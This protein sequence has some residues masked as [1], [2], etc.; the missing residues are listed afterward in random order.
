LEWVDPVSLGDN[1]ANWR[2]HPERQMNALKDLLG[3]SEVGWAGVLLFNEKTGHLIDGHARKKAAIARGEAAVPV[4][5][6]NWSPAAERKILLT[7]DPLAG[8][9]EFDADKLQSLLDEVPLGTDA[10]D[11]LGDELAKMLEEGNQQEA[12]GNERDGEAGG[13]G[14]GSGSGEGNGAG[15]Q[16]KIVIDCRSEREQLKLLKRFADEG[17]ACKALSL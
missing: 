5:I 2:T 9:A 11:A 14:S 6:G 8:M 15:D 12:A 17:L 3:D 16:F 1:P 4:V 13:K 10:L 7:L